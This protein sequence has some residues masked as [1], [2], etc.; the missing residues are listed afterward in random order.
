MTR[1]P[2]SSGARVE[3]RGGPTAAPAARLRGASLLIVAAASAYAAACRDAASSR[4][5]ATLA[6]A[7]VTT[8]SRAV[9]GADLDTS[10]ATRAAWQALLPEL[11]ADG[12]DGEHGL[13]PS[14]RPV[15]ELLPASG[16]PALLVFWATWCAPCVEELP[17]LAAMAREGTRIAA[18]SMDRADPERARRLLREHGIRFPSG[19]LDS[20]SIRRAGLALEAGLP[21]ALVLGGGGEVRGAI[22]GRL[23]RDRISAALVLGRDHR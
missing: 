7:P 20:A 6:D 13:T 17:L 19:I 12:L 10:D 18:V 11:R 21:F 15:A 5:H 14:G 16:S 2:P 4:E 3:A 1:S 9:G 8:S 22:G 23:D